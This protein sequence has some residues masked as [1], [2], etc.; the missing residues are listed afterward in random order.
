[1]RRAQR[2]ET[3]PPPVAAIRGP[4]ASTPHR[5]GDAGSGAGPRLQRRLLARGAG[6][7]SAEREDVV[8]MT[9]LRKRIAERLVEAQH[10]AA[11]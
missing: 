3:I 1:M 4:A 6:P 5:G 10:D 2:E 8:P 9:P 11:S 7:G